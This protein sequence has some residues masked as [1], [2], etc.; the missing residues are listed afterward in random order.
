MTILASGSSV[1][2]FVF[3]SLIAAL[4]TVTFHIISHSYNG[5]N[6]SVITRCRCCLVSMAVASSVAGRV[7]CCFTSSSNLWVSVWTV[8]QSLCP[9]LLEVVHQ[10]FQFPLA[11]SLVV[12][13]FFS[14]QSMFLW[15]VASFASALRRPI[16]AWSLAYLSKAHPS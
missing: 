12:F 10:E 7:I 8:L 5:M 2:F 9:L 11:T 3:V 15:H 14:N 1:S 16:Q 4:F 6:S 13:L